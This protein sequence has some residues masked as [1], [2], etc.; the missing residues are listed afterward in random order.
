MDAKRIQNAYEAR[1]D[2]FYGWREV[3]KKAGIKATLDALNYPMDRSV[4]LYYIH[5]GD[6]EPLN[7]LTCY[8]LVGENVTPES[9][10]R[11]FAMVLERWH[12]QARKTNPVLAAANLVD[13]E[14]AK[15]I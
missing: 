8:S 12:P 11:E 3:V 6:V 9:H 4:L 15:H 14:A 13:E 2:D 10:L 7:E 5:C 1:D